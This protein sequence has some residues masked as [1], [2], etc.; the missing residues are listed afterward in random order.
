MLSNIQSFPV[1]P[2][3]YYSS[4]GFLPDFE[5]FY[6]AEQVGGKDKVVQGFV[7]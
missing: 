5:F 2:A 6:F 4:P 1:P 7:V 3:G